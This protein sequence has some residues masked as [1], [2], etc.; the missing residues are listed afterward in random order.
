MPARRTS[1]SRCGRHQPVSV[2]AKED[3]RLVDAVGIRVRTGVASTA[4]G[5]AAPVRVTTHAGQEQVA[6]SAV[7]VSFYFDDR[8][9]V[10]AERVDNE[11]DPL[12]LVEGFR[13]YLRIAS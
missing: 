6:N 5:P 9:P 8:D 11:G 7:L 4:L 3:A 2:P 13:C 1:P 12:A 10:V